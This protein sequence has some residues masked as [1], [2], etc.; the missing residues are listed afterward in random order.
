MAQWFGKL[1]QTATIWGPW[2]A[3]IKVVGLGNVIVNPCSIQNHVS[4]LWFMD[5]VDE[6][7]VSDKEAVQKDV[8]SGWSYQYQ[9]T[10]KLNV[11]FFF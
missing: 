3:Q 11:F 2:E 7:I 8:L 4:Y 5:Y 1:L 9:C 10:S 6:N